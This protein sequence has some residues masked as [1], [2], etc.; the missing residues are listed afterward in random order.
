MTIDA[1]KAN[2]RSSLIL[3]FV[4]SL[5]QKINTTTKKTPENP[6]T[7]VSLSSDSLDGG[8]GSSGGVIDLFKLNLN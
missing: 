8:V 7:F 4:N 2:I 6:R 3:P 5:I 1:M